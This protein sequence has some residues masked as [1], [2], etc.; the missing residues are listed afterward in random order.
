M[1]NIVVVGTGYWGK[2]LVLHFHQLGALLGICDISPEILRSFQGKYPDIR[3]Y[4]TLDTVLSDSAVKA[5]VVS[6]PAATHHG[7]AKAALWA[8]K[9]VFVEKPISLHYADGEELVSLAASKGL[10]LMVGHILE[11]H[12]AVN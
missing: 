6:T 2:N 8:G 4:S 5:V 1:K 3:G 9:D 11:Y 10:V 12:P 7:I